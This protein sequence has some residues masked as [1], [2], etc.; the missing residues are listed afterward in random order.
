M[1][2]V[3]KAGPFVKTPSF[4]P[5]I[6]QDLYSLPTT[7]PT[8]KV[9]SLNSILYMVAKMIAPKIT[10]LVNHSPAQKPPMAPHCLPDMSLLLWYLR[11]SK[12]QSSPSQLVVSLLCF[13]HLLLQ[14]LGRIVSFL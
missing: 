12:E 3:Y 9:S 6:Q 14:P 10:T 4:R 5:S 2:D 1:N 11:A 13:L 8:S 7:L